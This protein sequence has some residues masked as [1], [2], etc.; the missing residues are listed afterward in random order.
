MNSRRVATILWLLML[1]SSAACAPLNMPQPTVMPTSV[2]PAPMSTVTTTLPTPTLAWTTYANP[3]FGIVLQYPAHWQPQP[4]Y[5][6]RFAGADGFFQLA[7]ISGEGITIDQ[8]ADNEAHHK[9]QSYG[10]DPRIEELRLQG[11][12]TRLIFPSADQPETMGNQAGLIIHLPQPIEISGPKYEY[13]ILWVDQNHIRAIAQ[14][15]KLDMSIVLTWEGQQIDG[16]QQSLFL[17]ADGRA[18]IAPDDILRAPM[19]ILDAVD[20]PQQWD[21]LQERFAP[22]EADTLVG[23]VIFRGHGQEVATPAWQRA[24]AAWA[25]LVRLEIQFGRSGAS[26]GAALSWRQEIPERLGYCQFLHVEVYGIAYTSIARCGGG[27]AQDLGYGWLETAEWEQFDT[28]FYDRAPL[29]LGQPPMFVP[30]LDLFAVGSQEM[31]ASEIEA[32]FHWAEAVYARL[33]NYE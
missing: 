22:F 5:E 8:V 2:L 21:Y 26:W 14:T 4:G 33:K 23:H 7:A 32:L 31:N 16:S 11:R 30:G 6:R 25:R 17:L 24:I 27:D 18:A 9:L 1:A 20:R 10:S 3:L 28:W 13:L 29:S 12:E 15:I 19:R